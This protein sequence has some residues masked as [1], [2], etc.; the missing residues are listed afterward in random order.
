MASLADYLFSGVLVRFPTLKL[1]YSEG[2]IG[3]IPYALERADNVWEYHASWTG[4]KETIP[5]PP[6]DATTGAGSSA[7]SRTTCT[8]STSIAEV[9]EDN[10]C[11]ETDYPHTDTTWPFAREEVERMTAALTDEQRYKVLRGNA[12]RMLDLDPRLNGVSGAQAVEAELPGR[13]GGEAHPRVLD[14]PVAEP[15]V[16]HRLLHERRRAA[17][18]GHVDR[19]GRVRGFDEL[20]HHPRDRR[21]RRPSPGRDGRR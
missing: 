20:A 16:H 21:H 13:L 9:G 17:R 10:I 14:E 7:A 11:F 2:Q 19:A 4:V 18:V 6:V 12:I 3:W 8:A 15:A 5:E 1:A